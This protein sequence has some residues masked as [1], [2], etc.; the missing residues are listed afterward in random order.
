[1]NS[2]AV[3]DDPLH[4]VKKI[5]LHRRQV[6]PSLFR[7]N[8]L[9]TVITV[10][11]LGSSPSIG[12]NLNDIDSRTVVDIQFSVYSP[13]AQIQQRLAL[14]AKRKPIKVWLF[15]DP[16][17]GLF[18]KGLRIRLREADRGAELTLKVANQDCSTAY[19]LSKDKGKCK[20]KCEYDLHGTKIIGALSLTRR[21]D[22]RTA[23]DLVMGRHSLANVLSPAQKDILHNTSGAW[24]LPTDLRALGPTRVS[25]YRAK[26][27]SA[28][29]D[30][31]KPPAGENFIEISSKVVQSDAARIR[32]QMEDDLIKAGVTVCADQSAQAVNKFQLLLQ[33]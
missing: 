27:I 30:V 15:D 26:A 16:T 23:Q 12:A 24:P 5:S 3:V 32:N 14:H 18:A 7:I 20:G 21:V 25:S 1:M 19:L 10:G 29:V 22:T 4:P 31:S 8:L 17:L 11:A 2:R 13:L 33:R 6:A 28:T 9:C